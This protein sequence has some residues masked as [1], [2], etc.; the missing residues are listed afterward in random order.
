MDKK[1]VE[2]SINAIVVI[3]LALFV[4]VVLFFVLQRGII[5]G[6]QKYFNLSESAEKEIRAENVCAK[7]F[8]GRMCYPS[9]CPDS[10]VEIS[11]DWADCRK[12]SNSAESGSVVCCEKK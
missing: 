10:Y 4:L 12:E 3:V 2:L 9:S 11:G 5:G 8:S 6:T 7:I 1:G